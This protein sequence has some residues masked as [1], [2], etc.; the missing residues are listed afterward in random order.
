MPVV[1]TLIPLLAGSR[2][3]VLID[4][5]VDVAGRVGVRHVAGD[6]RQALLGRVHAGQSGG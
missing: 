3:L 6:H 2:D 1:S 4:A 5:L